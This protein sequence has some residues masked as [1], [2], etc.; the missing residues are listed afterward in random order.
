MLLG[1]YERAC[2]PWSVRETPW[3]FGA[4]LL[5]PD[6]ERI[7]PSL[8][9]GFEHFP[10]YADAGIRQVINGPFTFASDGNP[11]I[12]PIRGQPGHWV[13]C[14]VMAGLSQGGGVGLAMA[15]WMTSGDPGF[16]V[17]GMDVARYGDWTTPSYTRAKVMENYSRR[18]SICLLYTSP[19]PRD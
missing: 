19:S 17:W 15:N 16:D 9:V 3:D 18:F 5:T 10:I 4:Q 1:T 7:A 12:G 11:L 14:G 8:A 2:R 13:A 6:L